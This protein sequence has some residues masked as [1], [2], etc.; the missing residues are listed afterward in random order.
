MQQT[1]YNT[2]SRRYFNTNTVRRGKKFKKKFFF[3]E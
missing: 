1:G 2:L 3:A